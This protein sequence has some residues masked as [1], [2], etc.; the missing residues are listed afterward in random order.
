MKT[1][2]ERQGWLYATSPKSYQKDKLAQ[3]FN[4]SIGSNDDL[5][6]KSETNNILQSI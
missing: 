2:V 5:D 3:G 4:D 6:L 1:F